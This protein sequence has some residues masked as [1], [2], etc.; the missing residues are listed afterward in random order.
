M[1]SPKLPVVSVLKLKY[2]SVSRSSIPLV[3]K[4]VKALGIFRASRISRLIKIIPIP[5]YITTAP[6]IR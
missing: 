4:W 3:G 2:V 5:K 1:M 6:K